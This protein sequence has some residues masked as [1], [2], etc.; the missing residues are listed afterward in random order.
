MVISE[1]LLYRGKRDSGLLS[2]SANPALGPATKMNP[3]KLRKLAAIP[4]TALC[5]ALPVVVAIDCP[6]KEMRERLL[7]F[8]DVV[9]EFLQDPS[10]LAD[11]SSSPATSASVVL[12]TAGAYGLGSGC[13]LTNRPVVVTWLEKK[14]PDLYVVDLLYHLNCGGVSIFRVGQADTMLDHRGESLHAPTNEGRTKDALPGKPKP[15][16]SESN[17]DLV[18][19][20]IPHKPASVVV[21]P[22]DRAFYVHQIWQAIKQAKTWKQ[23]ATML[24]AGEWQHLLGLLE[25]KPSESEEFSAESLPGYSDGDYPPWLQTEVARCVPAAVL[26]ELGRKQDSVL[27]GPFWDIQSENEGLLVAR[28]GALGYGVER[29]DDWFFY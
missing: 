29:K 27:N 20:R 21:A 26:N 16:T 10:T 19:R 14:L 3:A 17:L 22:R 28:L 7:L 23:F 8:A 11:Q 12:V 5:H 24:P 9:R 15:P 18:Y 6:Q 2:Y 25:E 13:K 4:R 1:S